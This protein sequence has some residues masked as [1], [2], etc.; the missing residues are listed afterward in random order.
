MQIIVHDKVVKERVFKAGSHHCL[1][2]VK[3]NEQNLNAYK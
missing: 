1:V 3:C 2:D